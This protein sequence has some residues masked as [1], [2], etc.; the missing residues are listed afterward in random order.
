ML[1]FEA[2]SAKL[3]LAQVLGLVN[4]LIH[5]LAHM[6]QGQVYFYQQPEIAPETKLG[7]RLG[8]NFFHSTQGLTLARPLPE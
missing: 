4:M 6:R 1:K 8:T 3:S 2:R 5:N 7:E